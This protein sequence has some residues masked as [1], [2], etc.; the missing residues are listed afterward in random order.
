VIARNSSFTYKGRAVD[1]KHVA[2]ELGVRYVLEGSVRR[3]DGRI[4]VLA[5]L[6]DAET[7]NHIWAERY[8]RALEDV[9]A[10]Q[11]DIA[12]AASH[13]IA[14]A[15]SH[16]ERQRAVRKS[17]EHLDTWE[18][19]QR[20]LWHLAKGSALGAEQARNFLERAIQLDPLF[21]ASHAMLA[22][23]HLNTLNFG[24]PFSY[25]EAVSMAEAEARRAMELDPDEPSAL[26]ASAWVSFCEGDHQGALQRADQAI[27]IDPNYAGAY[28]AKATA[29][30][31]SGRTA[32]ARQ[33]DLVALRL[34]PRDPWG[35]IMRLLLT[36]AHYFEG[37]YVNTL[38]AARTAIRHY[39]D[40]PTPYRYVAASLG[41][42][43]RIGEA[44][45]ALRQAIT[46][47]PASFD[48]YVGSRL[49]W[50]RPEDY[51]H[52]LDGLRKAGWQG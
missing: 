39:P 42:L 14:P 16:A 15:I 10:V 40:Y 6:I 33:A 38:A 28:L 26:V 21:A 19:Y 1:V 24:P 29:L 45:E 11:D 2:R 31:Y 46:V 49:P 27:S 30:V 50:F 25:H 7:G 36:V 12:D 20:A 9:F 17:P 37:D 4:R 52:F 44:R 32:E 18:A 47:S 22:G 34:N 3:S 51:E 48:F 13:A 43:G 35:A 8:D 41:Q 23:V 5:R